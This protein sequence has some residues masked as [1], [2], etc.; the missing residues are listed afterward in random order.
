MFRHILVL[1]DGSPRS[2]HA[3]GAAARLA[4]L[5]GARITAFH[6]APAFRSDRERTSGQPAAAVPVTP[7]EYDDR[8]SAQARRYLEDV[9]AL[10]E[11]EGVP[12][13]GR[14]A[15]SDFPAEAIAK[16]VDQYA[17][18]TIAIGSRRSEGVDAMG[19]MAQQILLATR[20]PVIVT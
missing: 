18:D 14:Y 12:F 17:C 13:D 7:A 20:V 3:A 16:A 6:V 19:S 4:K 10:A 5:S 15:T 2:L 1:T 8:V 11:A 9:R